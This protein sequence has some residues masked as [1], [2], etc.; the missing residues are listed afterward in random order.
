[1]K[2]TFR[3]LLADGDVQQIR[4]STNNGLTGYKINKLQTIQNDPGTTTEHVVKIFTTSTDGTGASR[5]AIDTINFDDPT[6]LAVA[7]LQSGPS[8]SSSTVA[9]EVIIFDSMT[10][11][12]DVFVTCKVITGSDPANYYLELEQ[13]KLDHNEATVATLKDMRSGPSSFV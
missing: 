7:Y 1:M 6:L 5:T 10:V 3:G 11:N 9:N 2:K 13:T 12:Q 4:L 8:A